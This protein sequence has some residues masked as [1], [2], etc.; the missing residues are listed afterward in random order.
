MNWQAFLFDVAVKSL[1]VMAI[2]A[3]VVCFYR[4]SSAALKHRLWTLGL[5]SVL[6]LPL[7]SVLLPSYRIAVLPTKTDAST[8]PSDPTIQPKSLESLIHDPQVWQRSH[9]SSLKPTNGIAPSDDA[10]EKNPASQKPPGQLALSS[11][12]VE[13]VSRDS[14]MPVTVESERHW[15]S[16]LIVAWAVGTLMMLV[17]WTFRWW[18]TSR[19]MASGT[20]IDDRPVK[21]LHAELCRALLV[22]ENVRLL[23]HPQ[24]AMP[25]AAGLF[26]PVV[27]LPSL[28]TS[29]SA[30]RLRPVL[31]HELAHVARRDTLIQTMGEFCRA[32]YWFNPLVWFAVSRLPL[33]RE[34]AC[35]DHVLRS[36]VAATD[37]AEVLLEVARDYRSAQRNVGLAMARPKELQRRV[38]ALLDKTR[39]HIPVGKWTAISMMAALLMISG[40]TSTL[41]LV[42]RADDASQQTDS[43]QTVSDDSS[44]WLE[45]TGESLQVR[46]RAQVVD[47][48]GAPVDDPEVTITLRLIN[49]SKVVE[50]IVRDNRFQAVVP[51][52]GLN[53]YGINI[54]CE[55][56]GELA[57]QF[58][59]RNQVRQAAIDGLKVQLQRPDRSVS[60]LVTHQD[61]PI[62]GAAVKVT[63]EGNRVARGEA[64]DSGVAYVSLYPDEKIDSLTAWTDD[65]LIGG[66]QFDRQP[67]RD[68]DVESLTIEM[69]S[70]RD[71]IVRMIDVDGKPIEGVKFQMQIATPPPYF[72]FLGTVDDQELQTDVN[73]K[74]V[75]H[76][77]PDWPEVHRYADLIG[78]D[79]FVFKKAERVED[80][81]VV[82]L[83]PSV[84]RKRV[85]GRVV[86]GDVTIDPSRLAG[87][88][89]RAKSFQAER[90]NHS[91]SR[92]A[93]TDGT[94]Q[95]W[96]DAL[97]GATYSIFVDDQQLVSDYADVI[98]FDPSTKQTTTP[99]L[100]LQQGYL[101]KARLT[102]GPDRSP[103]PN[104]DVYFRSDHS[105]NWVE[106]GE[107]KSG[108]G[109]RGFYATTDADGVAI[110]MMPL[111]QVQVNV[112]QP[113]WQ[114]RGFIDVGDGGENSVTLHREIAE[115][116]LVVGRV[117]VPKG[118]KVQLQKCELTIGAL[119]GNAQDKREMNVNEDGTFS[120]KT[121]ATKLGVFAITEDQA[122]A[123]SVISSDLS[124]QI[125]IELKTTETFNGRLVDSAGDPVAERKITMYARMQDPTESQKANP[126]GVIEFP[127][128][129]TASKRFATTNEQGEFS[130]P[131][132]P[133][134]LEMVF[135]AEGGDG[136]LGKV[137]LE[138][139]ENRPTTQWK[140]RAKSTK[141]KPSPTSLATRWSGVLGNC[142]LGGYHAM[143]IAW[144]ESEP[145]K[146]FVDDHLTTRRNNTIA[147][148]FMTLA[149]NGEENGV[150]LAKELNLTLPPVGQVTAIA[151]ESDGIEIGRRTFVVDNAESVED[152][153][154]FLI[155]NAPRKVD[156]QQAWDDA[157][158]LAKQT[159][160][161]VW[162]RTAGRYCGPCFTLARLLEDHQELLSKDFVMLKLEDGDRNE[163][164]EL[165]ERLS[166]GK[167]YGI[168]FHVIYDADGKRII[169]SQGPMGNIGSPSSFEGRKHFRRMLDAG[170]IS[171][172]DDEINEI[173]KSIEKR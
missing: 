143:V 157:F 71:Q 27:M 78:D 24:L 98:L 156:A 10:W 28:A 42:A 139:G 16:W 67:V 1:V 128:S 134:Y 144:E 13:S 152:A 97:P 169:D 11:L 132:L 123:G 129:F 66:F 47:S 25:C 101:A 159:D 65:P 113:E 125:S 131:G 126:L 165:F 104:Q 40:T 36:G 72:N 37:Y 107:T 31:L 17:P 162:V 6:V 59:N 5:L 57:Q 3:C 117:V 172:T 148:R 124:K 105:Y 100:T 120:I 111:G 23:H 39:S 84:P 170:R 153:N 20:P 85:M 112:Y 46:L 102:S 137:F 45:G 58:L 22:S 140:L 43:E 171:L 167:S 150:E 110:A 119:D 82:T 83:K 160:R 142:R 9:V 158:A 61:R 51:A 89:I 173:I 52:V 122:Y 80:A 161:R 49:D 64:N 127:V 44:D 116:R 164:P 138:P 146:K 7:L 62:A 93:M 130:F 30:D 73:G 15:A 69:H 38:G 103:I 96:V 53:W 95:F 76:W 2:V 94:G 109:G 141:Q 92:F 114:S 12:T 147:S 18:C 81:L 121:I 90:D 168:P 8:E 154:D 88:S 74:A 14:V 145:A 4:N 75:V 86:A 70:C 32:V 68:R 55:K 29:W 135:Y 155:A 63:M 54:Q 50:S 21:S 33:E 118:A 87:I 19:W 26:R 48:S 136:R 106:K 91:D 35:D 77:Y 163:H 60:V 108:G 151:F 56:N 149:Y 79:W 115:P 41:R 99:T 166:Q 133:T 34:Q